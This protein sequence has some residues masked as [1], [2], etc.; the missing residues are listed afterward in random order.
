MDV[1]AKFEE[2]SFQDIMLTRTG[3]KETQIA[4]ALA[5][6]EEKNWM[7]YLDVIYKLTDKQLCTLHLISYLLNTT[8]SYDFKESRLDS[9]SGF[10]ST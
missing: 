3:P 8:A 6:V 4:M 7:S 5:G 1:S 2:N 9:A 10:L